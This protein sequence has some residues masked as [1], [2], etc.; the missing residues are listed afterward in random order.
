MRT[1]GRRS[2]RSGGVRWRL[3]CSRKSQGSTSGGSSRFPAIE[4]GDPARD[5]GS[6]PA[7]LGGGPRVAG[8]ARA[9]LRGGPLGELDD[10]VGVPGDLLRDPDDLGPCLVVAVGHERGVGGRVLVA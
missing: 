6:G 4:L 3:T 7:K 2:S 1:A 10:L 8:D 9:Q 5:A